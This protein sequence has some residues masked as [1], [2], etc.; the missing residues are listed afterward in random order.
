MGKFRETRRKP[1]FVC[2]PRADPGQRGPDAR[3]AGLSD[4][5][6]CKIIDRYEAGGTAARAS[7][8]RRRRTGGER[9]LRR[10]QGTAIRRTTC[11][12]QPEPLKMED[13]PWSRAAVRQLIERA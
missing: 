1:P 7:R 12:R 8:V 4:P 3:D 9:V 13:A 10:A 5:A 11:D 2:V 6:T